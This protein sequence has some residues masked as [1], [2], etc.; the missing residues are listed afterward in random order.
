VPIPYFQGKFTSREPQLLALLLLVAAFLL[1]TLHPGKMGWL[2]SLIPLPVF[3]YLVLLGKKAGSQLI[4]NAIFISGGAA[5]LLG[6]LPLLVF[7]LTLV[8]LGIAFLALFSRVSA[9]E[10]ALK[11]AL[12]LG[13]IWI[14]FWV[15][16]GLVHATNPYTSLLEEMDKGLTSG[17]ALYQE[18]AELS[19]ETLESIRGAV[20]LMRAYVPKVLPSLLIS[21]VLCTTWLN[22]AI[23]NW[24]LKN[25]DASLTPWPAY[26]GWQLPDSLVW[27]II[28][29]GALLILLP[30]PLSTV[31]LNIIFICGTIFFFQGLAVV[32]SLL[33]KWSVPRPIRFLIYGLIFIQTYGIILLSFLGLADVWVDFRKLNPA[34]DEQKGPVQKNN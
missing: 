8:P 31:G 14:V 30:A 3:Y 9:V 17:F 21:V 7:S 27:G 2:T 25:K 5:L 11:G 33:F 4:R 16:F 34:D 28:F 13:I 22:L 12:V 6:S 18:N 29:G 24:L 20:E 15:I 10:A 23:G 1:P 19:P 32:S 26:K